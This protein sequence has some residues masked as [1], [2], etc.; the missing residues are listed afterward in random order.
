MAAKQSPEQMSKSRILILVWTFH[1]E[2]C[3]EKGHQRHGQRYECYRAFGHS[4]LDT[5]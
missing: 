3:N 2:K 4:R 5:Q 1:P